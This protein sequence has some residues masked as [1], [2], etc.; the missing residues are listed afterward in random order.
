MVKISCDTYGFDCTFQ[1]EGN[2]SEVM[3]QYQKHSF[4]EHGIEYSVEVLD[5]LIVRMRNS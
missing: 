3:D 1:V 4:D 2:T 5:Q